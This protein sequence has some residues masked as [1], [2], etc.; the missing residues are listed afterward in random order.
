MAKTSQ[1]AKTV[2]A[3]DAHKQ[4]ISKAYDMRLSK[5]HIFAYDVTNALRD[6][7]ERLELM[8]H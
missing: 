1:E 3:L 5:M 7:L 6:R 4:H 2:F 8:Q